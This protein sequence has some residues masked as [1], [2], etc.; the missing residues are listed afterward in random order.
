VGLTSLTITVPRAYEI[1]RRYQARGVPVVLGGIHATLLPDE[2]A[3]YVDVVFQGEAEGNW[4]TLVRD[5]EAGRL[6]RRYNGR[7][8]SLRG[9]PLP[10]RELY[11]RHYF[12]QLVSASRGCHGR[13]EFC[14]LWS[15]TAAGIVPGLPVRCSTSSTQ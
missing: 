1:A 15:W 6:A 5:F 12:L 9:L 3:R 7:A 10:R 2:V 4:P 13:C 14:T 11:N 8:G